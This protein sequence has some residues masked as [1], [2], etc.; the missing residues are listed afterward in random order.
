MTEWTIRIFAPCAW[1]TANIERHHLARAAKVKKWRQA[2]VAACLEAQ[3]PKG[4]TPVRIHAQVRYAGR[5]PVRDRLNLAPT[6]KAIVDAL[7]PPRPF[8]KTDKRTGLP[9]E[10]TTVGYGFLPDDNDRHV[11]ETTWALA[12]IDRFDLRGAIGRIDLALLAYVGDHIDPAR[13]I[14]ATPAAEQRPLFS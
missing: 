13:H 14:T 8:T 11:L 3:L 4:V 2:V 12:P 9:R 7:T 6:I 5:A 10:Y 1:L